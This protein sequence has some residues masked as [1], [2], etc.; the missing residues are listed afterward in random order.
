[1]DLQLILDNNLAPAPAPPRFHGHIAAPPP[2]GSPLAYSED[3]IVNLI[4]QI[5]T[6]LM[7]LGHV[8][9]N[10]FVFPPEGGHILDEALCIELNLAP[11]V[12]SLLRRLPYFS[13][14]SFS[15]CVQIWPG[16][17]MPNYLDPSHL[18]LSR[19]ILDL[20]GTNIETTEPV[21][22]PQDVILLFQIE[23]DLGENWILDTQ[24]SKY[25]FISYIMGS[26]ALDV[27]RYNPP[28]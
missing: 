5:L 6:L 22:Q 1:M 17:F 27:N 25:T 28:L 10:D 26:P 18:R 20:P 3:V 21:L 14:T 23:A 15:E 7:R 12:V 11:S 4:I 8:N 2:V 19:R 13:K 16:S 9:R 24:A